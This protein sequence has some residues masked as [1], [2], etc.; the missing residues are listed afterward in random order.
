MKR[1][2]EKAKAAVQYSGG[3]NDKY[4]NFLEGCSWAD[5]HP[6]EA[7]I[8]KYLYEKKGYP[9]SF[10]GNIPSFEE[11]MKVAM[12]DIKQYDDYKRKQWMDSHPQWHKATDKLPPKSELFGNI[13]DL[14][15]ATDG[16]NYE[17]C[18][19]LHFEKEWSCS[20]KYNITHWIELPK[21]D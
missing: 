8:A 9:I 17:K 14:V 5:S 1:E 13:S 16:K 7:S 18:R 2:E 21:E 4:Y 6:S 11:T 10:N 19:Y 3:I 15:L 12:K 20:F